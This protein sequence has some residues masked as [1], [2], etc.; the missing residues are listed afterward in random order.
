MSSSVG[1]ALEQSRRLAGVS[2]SWRLD[3]ELLLGAACGRPRE[4]LLAHDEAELDLSVMTRFEDMLRR[5][6]EG[7]PLAYILE[8]KAFWDVELAVTPAVLIPRP[9]TE[10]LV[11]WTEE[12]LRERAAQPLEVVDLGTGSG[13]IAIALARS[14]PHWRLTAV[15]SDA[16]ALAVARSNA[17]RLKLDNIEF[18]QGSWCDGLREAGY[19]AIVSNP[20]YVA[21]SDPHLREDGLA[22]EPRQALVAGADGLDCL[23]QII[24][25]AA[26][27]LKED[28]WLLLEH[29]Y[30][31]QATVLQ[32]LRQHGY[33]QPCGRQDYTGLDRVVAAQR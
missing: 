7:E 3:G 32:L 5:R 21:E 30:E 26:W 25:Q 8:C 28:A 10:L 31:Q 14:N 16:D 24:E 19:D 6:L 22:F 11:E 33:R 12:L 27:Y 17:L 23:R 20:P 15:D 9:E 2:D 29:G 4:W 1:A 18:R 13:A